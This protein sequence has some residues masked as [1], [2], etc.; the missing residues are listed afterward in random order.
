MQGLAGTGATSALA[1]AAARR[2]RR[3]CRSTLPLRL[4]VHA[5]MGGIK[6][7]AKI[8]RQGP[9]V[10]Q[11]ATNKSH[12]MGAGARVTELPTEAPTLGL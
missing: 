10:W 12:L 2:L 5:P 7:T 1:G 4:Q 8:Y 9:M 3:L 6:L 11:A